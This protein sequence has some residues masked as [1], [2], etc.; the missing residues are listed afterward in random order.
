MGFCQTFQMVFKVWSILH[1]LEISH[2]CQERS[3]IRLVEMLGMCEASPV[4]PPLNLLLGWVIKGLKGFWTGLPSRSIWY[5]VSVRWDNF[6]FKVIS[7]G[8][9][10]LSL[11]GEQMMVKGAVAPW[12][13]QAA[14][15][16]IVGWGFL[17]YMSLSMVMTIYKLSWS[18]KVPYN[19][20]G[21]VA[22]SRLRTASS[23]CLTYFAASWTSQMYSPMSSVFGLK[24]NAPPSFM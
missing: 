1:L 9:L 5:K 13:T 17:A 23:P 24:E 21:M 20:V 12:A 22:L 19:S 2:D 16:A 15:A 14:A 6:S 3:T 4:K 10:E 7:L 11:V 18:Y 8:A